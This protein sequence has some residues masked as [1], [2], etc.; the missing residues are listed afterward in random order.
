MNAG[1]FWSK[2]AGHRRRRS[3]N[4]S[5]G[6]GGVNVDMIVQNIAEEGRKRT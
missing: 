5:L 4:G 3:F 1:L 6:E 2:T